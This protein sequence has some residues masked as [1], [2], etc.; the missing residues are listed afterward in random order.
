MN[1]SEKR[2]LDVGGTFIKCD[3]GRQ[4][5]TC[6]K[7]TAEEMS[8]AFRE[9]VGPADSLRQLGVAI[10][11]PFDF[12]KGIFL[13]K[14]K[15][16]AAYGLSFRELAG[17]PPHVDVKYLHDVNAVLVGA[18]D[19]LGLRGCNCAL[20]TLGTG[21]GYTCAVKGEV[22]CNEMG[23]PA[24]GLWNRPWEDG[25]LEDRISARGIRNAYEDITGDS[26]QSPYGIAQRAFAGEEAALRV[27][28]QTGEILAPFLKEEAEE[29]GLSVILFGGQISKSLA[30]MLE[31]MTELLGD[32]QLLP[33]P[34]GAVFRGLDTLFE[35]V[36]DR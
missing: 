14:H 20:V 25:M 6:S 16:D 1:K 12:R 32:V 34:E 26:G 8:A 7:G 13:M 19:M 15:F 4:V 27:F 31:P 24:R 21:L 30:L 22:Q 11:G 23:S 33:A 17:I 3:D 9:A 28:R 36:K 2:C 29:L 10:P 18:V 35:D 5:P